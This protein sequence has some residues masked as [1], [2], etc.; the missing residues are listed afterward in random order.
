MNNPNIIN[1][2]LPR[3]EP[4]NWHSD[5]YE[6]RPMNNAEYAV[7]QRRREMRF[8]PPIVPNYLQEPSP[9]MHYVANQR[10][11]PTSLPDGED[12]YIARRDRSLP[13]GEDQIIFKQ[14]RKP[15]PFE[16]GY[17]QPES[18]DQNRVLAQPQARYFDE[19]DLADLEQRQQKAFFDQFE[20][21][22]ALPTFH[23]KK[24]AY[25][26]ARLSEQNR[27]DLKQPKFFEPEEEP[28]DD[29]FFNGIYEEL[30]SI[31]SSSEDKQQEFE[32]LYNQ[33]MSIF[34]QLSTE[35]NVSLVDEP[36]IDPY[37]E[38]DNRQCQRCGV[39]ISDTPSHHQVCRRCY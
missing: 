29:D 10:N 5:D 11:P 16:P 24:I 4:T 34:D 8:Q 38:V 30:D 1:Q 21:V 3:N 15:Y 35:H 26:K 17:V 2:D 20:D 23:P 9:M 27:K 12:E 14:P 18:S 31:L 19:S 39:D 36:E 7:E 33:I 13:V 25:D 22:A 28:E 6:E 32:D 37:Q